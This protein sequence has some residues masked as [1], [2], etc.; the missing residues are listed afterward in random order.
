[1]RK[2]DDHVTILRMCSEGFKWI[3]NASCVSLHRDNTKQP[4]R[5]SATEGFLPLYEHVCSVVL[6]AQYIMSSN[7]KPIHKIRKFKLLTDHSHTALISTISS[8][9]EY[10]YIYFPQYMISRTLHTFK[11]ILER[12]HSLRFVFVYFTHNTQCGN[13]VSLETMGNSCE[14]VKISTIHFKERSNYIHFIW[15]HI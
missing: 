4:S 11:Q 5:G 2:I 14:T 8:V 3:V 13:F 12:N 6:L 1:M 7:I 9:A 10:P 15:W